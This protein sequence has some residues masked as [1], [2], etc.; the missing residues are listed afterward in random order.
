M[1]FRLEQALSKL[2]IAFTSDTLIPECAI[3]CAVGNICD[4]KDMWRHLTDAHGSDKLNYVGLVNE[5]FGRKING[6]L[7]SELLKIEAVFL[8]ACGYSL[9]LK[10][11]SKRPGF[12]VSKDN[13]FDGLAA[14]IEYLCILDGTQSVMDYSG[15]FKYQKTRSKK[16]LTDDVLAS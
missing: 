5:G 6:Y 2:Y 14:V 1:T 4:N 12:K 7:P 11:T 15:F 16:L 9:P 13:L 10:P 3:H 8:K